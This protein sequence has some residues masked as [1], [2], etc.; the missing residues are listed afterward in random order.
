MMAERHRLRDLQMGEAGHHCLGMF[1]GA[2]D[3][4]ALQCSDRIDRF[5]AGIANPQAGVGRDLIVARSGGVQPS[6]RF[7][8][9]L[10]QA[11]LHRHV[12]V[13]EVDALG[14]AVTLIFSRDL[15][16]PFEHCGRVGLRN[17][18]LFAEHRRMRLGR[19]YILAPQALVEADRSVDARHQRVRS[20]PEPA[21]PSALC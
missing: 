17:D 7:A 5:V 9:Q 6:R 13:L 21:T 4:H 16:Q 3:Q 11:M 18:A 10:A 15:V 1:V 14:N 12:D 8:D 19:G 20:A 2:F